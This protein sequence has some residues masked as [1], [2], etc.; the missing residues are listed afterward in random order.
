MGPETNINLAL[1]TVA[2]E[3]RGM[4]QSEL[5]DSIGMSQARLSKIEAG[6]SPAPDDF[7]PALSK[8]LR[9]PTAFFFRSGRAYGP[10]VSELFHRKRAAAGAKDLRRSTRS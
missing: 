9:Y 6:L 3:S 5:A 7:L 8:E 1:V 4:T 10:G 2:R